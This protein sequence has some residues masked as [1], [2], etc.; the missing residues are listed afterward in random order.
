MTVTQALGERGASNGTGTLDDSAVAPPEEA[1]IEL[2]DGLLA[3]QPRPASVRDSIRRRLLAL[4]DVLG[5]IFA[6]G[7]VWLLDPP[8][9]SPSSRLVLLGALPVWVVLN[10]LLGLYDRDANVMH[11]STLDE[12]PRIVHSVVLGSSALFLI[13]PLLTGVELGR[14]QTLVFMAG[15]LAILPLLRTTVRWTV[16]QRCDAERVLIVGSGA[17]A[18]LLAAKLRKHPEYPVD[19]VGFVVEEW[20]QESV[21]EPV[22]DD[23]PALVGHVEDF[24]AICSELA[25][26]RVVIAFSTIGHEDLLGVV[27]TAKQLNLKVTVV[28]R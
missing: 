1:A 12:L 25:V 8:S 20:L 13:G 9:A 23:A 15:A 2:T 22:P 10:K 19:L 16:N 14:S 18:R 28:P 4:A 17:V 7:S 3:A 27:R 24:A 26:E 6:Y 21:H 5:L 11:G